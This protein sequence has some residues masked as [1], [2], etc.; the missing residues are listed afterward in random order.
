MATTSLYTETKLS[1]TVL[2]TASGYIYC[3][4]EW[5]PHVSL[6]RATVK[7][8]LQA[9]PLMADQLLVQDQEFLTFVTT[10]ELVHIDYSRLD[11]LRTINGA[12]TLIV[13]MWES[14][15]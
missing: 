7:T 1:N 8:N 13:G 9:F 2:R 10:Q 11:N 14:S 3:I 4:S 5:H 6:K 15:W 12:T